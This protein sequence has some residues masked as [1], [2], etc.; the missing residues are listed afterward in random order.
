M[1][2]AAQQ[3]GAQPVLSIAE[4][5][6]LDA[7]FDKKRHLI[8]CNNGQCAKSQVQRNNKDKTVD[9]PQTKFRCRTCT[10]IFTAYEMQQVLQRTEMAD[11]IDTLSTQDMDFILPT[12]NNK[13]DTMTQIMIEL[14]NQRERLDQHDNMYAEVQRLQQEL[15]AANA[16]IKSLQET[17][18][19]LRQQLS[20]VDQGPQKETDREFPPLPTATQLPKLT[21]SQASQWTH[22]LRTRQ[23]KAPISTET[24]QRRIAAAAR[25]F[26][27]PSDTHGFQYVYVPSCARQPT[28]QIR[29]NL[30]RFGVD[31]SRVLDI[32][33][34]ARQTIGLLVH[35]DYATILTEKL[36]AIEIIPVD[37]DPFD[38]KNINDPK[39]QDAPTDQKQQ[40]ARDLQSKRAQR[41]IQF[42]RAPVK[43]AVARAFHNYGWISLDV[44][45]AILATK[46]PH[47]DDPESAAENYKLNENN[48]DDDDMSDII[49]GNKEQGTK[50]KQADS[51]SRPSSVC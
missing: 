17:N 19:R 48:D 32:Q 45:K 9:P 44:L 43:F 16:H 35:N 23:K 26:Q 28:G 4:L 8:N 37:F 3:P 24:Q 27:L 33:Y 5:K 36:K 40:L 1:L 42:I 22:P 10:K 6:T 51:G 12:Q 38:P 14:K 34:P 20:G 11:Q 49:L 29:S 21:N 13:E 50:R 41:S 31:N 2:S 25:S 18:R 47:R 46:R 15:D 7:L 30:R 39:Y